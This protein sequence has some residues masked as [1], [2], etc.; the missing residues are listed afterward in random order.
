[1]HVQTLHGWDLTPAEAVAIQQGLRARVVT[2]AEP[3]PV[4]TVAGLDVST[5][6]QRA[7]A[8]VVV[9]SYPDQQPLEAVEA[10]LALAFPYVPG[11]LAFRE[12]PAIVAAL[13]LLETEPDLLLF[14]GHGL[15][16][17]RRIGLASHIGVIVDRPSIGCAKSLLCGQHGQVGLSEGAQSEIW[18]QDEVIG[19]AVRTRE[20]TQP[21]YVSIGHKV[22]LASAVSYVLNCTRGY[23]LPEPI[24]WAHRVAGGTKRPRLRLDR[25]ALQSCPQTESAT[26]DC[27]QGTRDAL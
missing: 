23:R 15:A 11:L 7:H 13:E 3:G 8:A 9:L 20:G 14:D 17:P 19:A 5:A 6:G 2:S 4:R 22:D 10:D 18:D 25:G 24:R 21:I 12:G 27:R 16:H 26:T 1:V